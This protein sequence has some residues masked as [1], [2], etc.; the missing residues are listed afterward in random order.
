MSELGRLALL[1]GF[2]CSVFAV[3]SIAWGLRTGLSGPLRSGRRA[4]WTVC[5]MALLAL[6]LLERALLARD[7]SYRY[8]A[9]HTSKDLPL[10]YAFTSLWAGQEGSLLLWLLI[11]SAYGSAFL[12]AY[13]KR[14]DPFY[15]AVAMVVASV[16]VFFTGLLS[17]VCSPFRILASPPPD[18][19]GLN[20]LLQDPGMMIHPPILYTGYVGFII[21]FGFAIA[22]L[23]TNRSGT[24][25]IEEVR[26][27]TLFCWGFLGVGVLLGARWAYIELGWGGYWGWD[28]VENAS[29]M[30]WLVGTAFLHSVMIEQRRGMLKTWNI[31][32][33]VLTFE[34]S[35]FG[36]FLTR[37]G[38]LTS[39]H[40][41]AESN[42]GP[43]F[44]AFILLSSTI[45]TAL[46]LYRKALLE[47]ENRMDA[48]VS[49]EGSFLFN[50]VLFVALTFATFLGTTFPVLSEAVT[51]TKISV[52]APFFNR[53]NVPIALALL[54]LTGAGPVLSW[55]R[56]TASVLQRNF[57][58]P[59]FMGTIALLISLPF[60]VTG[61]YPLV[62]IF[63]AAFVT[64]TIVMEFARGVQARRAVETG[65]LP[66][67]V[68]QLVRKNKRRYGGYIVHAGMVVLFVGVLGSSVF[69]KEAHGPLRNGEALHLGPYTLTLRGVTEQQKEN[70]IYTTAIVDVNR[71]NR[72]VATEHPAK[73]LYTK[74]Q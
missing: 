34:L 43:W 59:L 32:L 8:V 31:V 1:L 50:N 45:A 15:D 4:V 33:I 25:W 19:M 27:W 36:T 54:L 73:S 2:G 72:F 23:L 53:V 26:R 51:G 60:G 37:S 62:C 28:P 6:I 49:R 40:S 38:V 18:G 64:T 61:L 48:I 11:L 46:I 9:E 70:A 47:S 16:M 14:L 35:I 5:G 30:P 71:G 10:H 67:Q 55:K 58:L 39:V 57:V 29:L 68:T 65:G 41:F 56:A 13:R 42:I 12:F 20:P 7:M 17:F 74:S 3:G 24:R 44:L 22:V 21:P 69:Q 63:A 52:S 66:N